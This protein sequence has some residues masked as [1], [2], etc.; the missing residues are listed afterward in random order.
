MWST[1]SFHQVGAACWG[2]HKM[3]P[4]NPKRATWSIAEATIPRE[5]HQREKKKNEIGSGRGEGEGKATFWAVQ[6]RV[7][8]AEV[9][10]R[11]A[12]RRSSGGG[13]KGRKRVKEK[14]IGKTRRQKEKIRKKER[15]EGLKPTPGS[16]Q[17]H[18]GPTGEEGFKPDPLCFRRRF[19][20]TLTL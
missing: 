14:Q 16:H 1:T 7:G 9:V 20:K 2:S 10:K 3:T 19:D 4:V 17:P 12:V 18:S 13:K 15:T 11:A 8:P 6:R 5:D